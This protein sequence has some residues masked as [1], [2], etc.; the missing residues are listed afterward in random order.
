MLAMYLW[1][2]YNGE[3]LYG[4]I[5]CTGTPGLYILSW[6]KNLGTEKSIGFR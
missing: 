4:K 6:Q 1:T 5:G 3:S 2:L